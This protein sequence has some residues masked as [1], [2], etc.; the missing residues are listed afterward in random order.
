MAY[1][2]D[3]GFVSDD[4]KPYMQAEQNIGF[5]PDTQPVLTNDSASPDALPGTPPKTVSLA[6]VP[7]M[8]GDMGAVGLGTSAGQ[9]AGGMVPGLEPVTVPAFGALGGMAGDAVGQVRRINNGIQPN[10]RWGEML[11][12]GTSGMVPGS[13]LFGKNLSQVGADA[14]KYAMANILAK[15]VQTGV[16][17][18]QAATKGENAVAG[19]LGAISAPVSKLFDT[20]GTGPEIQAAQSLKAVKDATIAEGKAAGYVLAP[21]D[22]NP[23]LINRS[24]GSMG[25]KAAIGQQAALQNQDVTN[26]LAATAL[27]LPTDEPITASAIEQVRKQA[28]QAYEN[29]AAISPLAANH[30]EELKQARSDANLLFQKNSRLPDPTTLKNAKSAAADADVLEQ[31][32]EFHAMA[33]GKPELIPALQNARTTIAKSYVVENALNEATGDVSASD[34]GKLFAKGSPLTGELATIGKFQQA[35]PAAFTRDATKISGPGVNNLRGWLSS[36]TAGLGG[37]IGYHTHGI[38]GAGIGAA[39]G[40]YLPGSME[41][42]ARSLLLSNAYQNS[43]MSAPNYGFARPDFQALLARYATQAGGRM[44]N[45]D[46][47]SALMSGQPIPVQP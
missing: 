2:D 11:G 36:G 4:A 15:N 27:G 35:V 41:G 1:P 8:I 47:I 32:L 42:P 9:V 33:A 29:V 28:N 38:E 40:K 26:K 17:E 7:G 30:L 23:N 22:T 43:G 6:Q 20:G 14:A 24:L 21:Y 31:A 18:G 19:L 39:I 5:V 44:P 13:S 37:M 12:A 45:Q 3:L 10:F 16:D 46:Q 25:G 34:I